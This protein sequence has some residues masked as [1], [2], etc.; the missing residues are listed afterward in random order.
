MDDFFS[1][2]GQGYSEPMNAT[3]QQKLQHCK[4]LE[5]SINVE[6]GELKKIQMHFKAVESKQKQDILN[7]YRELR[8]EFKRQSAPLLK[9]LDDIDRTHRV[10][11]KVIQ[12]SISSM[13]REKRRLMRDIGLSGLSE[14]L[15][16]R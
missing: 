9:R 4:N 10:K 14:N 2:N 1:G 16:S 5:T 15:M 7:T 6:R 3:L 8:E 12:M 11:R 13:K